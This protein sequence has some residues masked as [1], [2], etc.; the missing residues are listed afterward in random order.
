M[1]TKER[2]PD[3][4]LQLHNIIILPGGALELYSEEVGEV[5]YQSRPTGV[6]QTQ[7]VATRPA[8]GVD[9]KGN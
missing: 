8:S 5:Q 3:P 6:A 2:I 1:A 9:S 7:D 4:N